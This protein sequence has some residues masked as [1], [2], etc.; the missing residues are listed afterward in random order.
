MVN[1]RILL[2]VAWK[3]VDKQFGILMTRFRRHRKEVEKEAGLSNLL[4]EGSARD[5]ESRVLLK[6][7]QQ[8]NGKL[9]S[10]CTSMSG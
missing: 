7:E 1:I 8:A 4:E 3:S 2:K 10:P 5:I 9:V 6:L